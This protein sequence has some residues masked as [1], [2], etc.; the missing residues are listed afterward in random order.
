M[1]YIIIVSFVFVLWTNESYAVADKEFSEALVQEISAIESAIDEGSAEETPEFN[2]IE[3]HSTEIHSDEQWY[4]QNFLI[5]L[6]PRVSFGLPG[7]VKIQVGPELEL[8]WQRPTPEGWV[9][10]HP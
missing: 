3:N 8:I 10:Y 4:F 5:R 9:A 1:K 6:R 2:E 7:L